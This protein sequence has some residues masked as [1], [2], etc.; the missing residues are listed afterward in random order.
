ML[1][2]L[3]VEVI[4]ARIACK[5]FTSNLSLLVVHGACS[6]RLLVFT[7][8]MMVDLDIKAAK[9]G[10]KKKGGNAAGHLRGVILRGEDL[11]SEQQN[12]LHEKMKKVRVAEQNSITNG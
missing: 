1:C 4:L 6:E 11:R 12:V 10:A 9:K 3:F 7:G 2:T 8:T 5:N